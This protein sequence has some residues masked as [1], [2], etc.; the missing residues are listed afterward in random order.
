[1]INYIVHNYIDIKS[2]H[3]NWKTFVLKKLNIQNAKRH[4][5]FKI[6]YYILRYLNRPLF[7]ISLIISA[8]TFTILLSDIVNLFKYFY[9]MYTSL[10]TIKIKIKKKIRTI[11]LFPQKFE[12]T[13]RDR[14][15][16]WGR[17]KKK[18]IPK[19][20]KKKKSQGKSS[21]SALVNEAWNEAWNTVRVRGRL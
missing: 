18:K 11:Q 17:K 21:V 8:W 3:V 13:R 10:S 9:Y 7:S 15:L 4:K 5:I 1:M 14:F 16:V 2:S 20:G 19:I 6:P 12:F